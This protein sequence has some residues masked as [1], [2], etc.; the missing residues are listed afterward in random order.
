MEEELGDEYVIVAEITDQQTSAQ[1]SELEGYIGNPYVVTNKK[2]GE[3]RIAGRDQAGKFKVSD[4]ERTYP[5]PTEVTRMNQDGT[6]TRETGIRG[7]IK[8]GSSKDQALDIEII[9]SGTVVINRIN[10]ID[11]PNKDDQVSIPIDTKQTNPTSLEVDQM[12]ENAEMMDEIMEKLDDLV[13]REILTEQEKED[14]LERISSNGK[15]LEEDLADLEQ[16]EK[17]YEEKVMDNER[18]RRGPW[19]P[20]AGY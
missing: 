16:L 19:D 6:Q 4:Y 8:F 14:K 1:L 9:G 7:T 20:P 3:I 18:E 5:S 11:N 10:N 13:E 15:P 12:R 2:T 17:I